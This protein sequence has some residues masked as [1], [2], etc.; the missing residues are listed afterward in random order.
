MC[1]EILEKKN[2]LWDENLTYKRCVDWGFILQILNKP[3]KDMFKIGCLGKSLAMGRKIK[4]QSLNMDGD[5]MIEE[6][7]EGGAK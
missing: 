1:T 5:K 2:V 3:N 4:G 6:M 7:A